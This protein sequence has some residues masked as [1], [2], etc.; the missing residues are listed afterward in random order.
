MFGGRIEQVAEPRVVYARPATLFTLGF[1]G[2]S[3]RIAG[4][5]AAS[6]DGRVEVDTAIG[7]LSAMGNFITGA[8]VVVAVRPE[9]LR[10]ASEPSGNCAS[11]RVRSIV[12]H[13]AN[14]LVEVEAGPA[15]IVYAQIAN[16]VS[17]PLKI[18]DMVSLSWLQAETFAFP[19]P[20]PGA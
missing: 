15:T 2:L 19:D 1:V 10:L 9:N 3:T 14:S 18:G 16:D 8:A 7:R 6:G 12:F 17:A 5:V 11:G 20:G 4:T 13:G